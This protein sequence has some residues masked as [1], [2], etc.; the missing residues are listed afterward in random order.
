MPG[1]VGQ[2]TYIWDAEAEAWYPGGF[3]TCESGCTCGPAPGQE[4]PY[5]GYVATVA[6]E[7]TPSSTTTSS[8]SSSSTTTSSTTTSTTTTAPPTTTTTTTGTGTTTTTTSTST[9]STT[10]TTTTEQPCTGTCTWRWYAD[11]Q[12]WIKV[13]GGNGTCSTGCSCSYPESN[14]TTDGETATPACKR[15][16]CTKCC[17]APCCLV[18]VTCCA[19]NVNIKPKLTLTI[20]SPVNWPCVDGMSF[21]LNYWKK[22]ASNNTHFYRTSGP[23]NYNITLSALEP[24]LGNL[25]LFEILSCGDLLFG[26]TCTI[27]PTGSGC[28]KKLRMGFIYQIDVD[29][30]ESRIIPYFATGDEYC[31]D[32]NNGLFFVSWGLTHNSLPDQS[33]CVTPFSPTYYFDNWAHMS[34][35]G[36]P[37]Q[38]YQKCQY[39]GGGLYVDMK[40][41]G[42]GTFTISITE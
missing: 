19:G 41:T 32:T 18:P 36:M 31:N 22:N 35:S 3:N 5:N 25:G 20:M 23:F 30:C 24:N 40:A 33:L 27:N 13:S 9:S 28:Y 16:T 42:T 1:C 38:G 12:K 21:T 4:G 14:G 6:C 39:R 15:L 11:L 17:G 26:P 7:G 8:S 34:P 29:Y 2:C 10:T 37:D